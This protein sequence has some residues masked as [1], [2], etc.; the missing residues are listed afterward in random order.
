MIEPGMRHQP[1]PHD[2]K[3]SR[4]RNP[5]RLRIRAFN[6]TDNAFLTG[7]VRHRNQDESRLH[8]A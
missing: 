6:D 4:M 1:S 7:F 8:H 2:K 3:H 5:E